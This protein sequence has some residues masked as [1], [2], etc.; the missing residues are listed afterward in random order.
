MGYIET[1]TVCDVV[2]AIILLIFIVKGKKNGL[3]SLIATGAAFLLSF[4]TAKALAPT[5]GEWIVQNYI[6]PEVE[7]EI[8]YRL[9]DVTAI[10]LDAVRNAVPEIL[11]SL[12]SSAGKDIAEMFNASAFKGYD[13]AAAATAITEKVLIPLILPLVKRA[14]FTVAFILVFAILKAVFKPIVA[15]FNLPVLKQLDSTAGVLVGAIKG[16]VI[17]V[18]ISML[19]AEAAS[20]FDISLLTRI[21]E[22]SKIISFVAGLIH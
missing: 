18:V 5:I 1:G 8:A 21:A 14:V 11:N 2:L 9:S 22:Q 16:L 15:V 13:S 20:I 12:I 4:L 3:S 19:I 7:G 6:S 10:T 17:V